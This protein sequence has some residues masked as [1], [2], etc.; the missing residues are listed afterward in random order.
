M[1]R[2]ADY[3]REGPRTVRMDTRTMK[4]FNR[5]SFPCDLELNHWDGVYST[6]TGP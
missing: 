4:N 6:V 1:I 3:I 5:E 2:K